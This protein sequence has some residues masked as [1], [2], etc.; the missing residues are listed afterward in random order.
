MR[1]RSSIS[2]SAVSWE[3]LAGLAHFEEVSLPSKPLSRRLTIFRCRSLNFTLAKRS[4][5]RVLS[6][7]EPRIVSDRSKA[8]PRQSRNH[9]SQ[10]VMSRSPF[11]VASRDVVIGL[12]FLPDLRRHAVKPLRCVFRTGEHRVGNR[13]RDAPVTVVERMDRYE[14][15]MR[16]PGFEHEVGRVILLEPVEKLLHFVAQ[17]IRH[18]SLV[19]YTFLPDRTRDDLHR[20]F[21]IIA[22]G[23]HFDLRHPAMAGREQGRVPGKQRRP[24][25]GSA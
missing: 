3:H 7:A 20:P 10:C 1:T 15:E 6:R 9:S 14:P 13:P 18:G 17:P 2:R 19:V 4:Q 24:V 16:D 11:C 8:R 5:N 12:L 22:P 21:R 23:P 25:S